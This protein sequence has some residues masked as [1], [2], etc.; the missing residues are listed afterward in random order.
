[1]QAAYLVH[2]VLLELALVVLLGRRLLLL[3]LLVL[4]L[5]G[6]GSRWLAFVHTRALLLL[7]EVLEGLVHLLVRLLLRSDLFDEVGETF[8]VL[9]SRVLH[10]LVLHS[11]T[12]S[13]SATD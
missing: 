4:L 5:V 3:L 7:F 12:I 9:A 8:D 6:L 13:H 1:M 2:Q 10:P 11:R